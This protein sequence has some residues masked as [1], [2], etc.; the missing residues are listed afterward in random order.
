MKLADARSARREVMNPV[1]SLPAVARLAELDPAT[2]AVVADILA[3][4]SFDANARAQASWAKSKGPMAAYWKAVSVYA[5]HFRRA[6][7]SIR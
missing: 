2:R 5:K 6:V 1:L 3:D 4:L 7:R